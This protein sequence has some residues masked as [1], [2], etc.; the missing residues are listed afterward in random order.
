[1]ADNDNHNPN[2]SDATQALQGFR[3]NEEWDALLAEVNA[4]IESINQIPYPNVS[5]QV[6]ALLQGI[7]AIHREALHRLVRLFKEGVLEQVIT[8]PAICTL[9]ELYDLLPAE[10]AKPN[11]PN[12]PIK[13]IPKTVPDTNRLHERPHWVP[14]LQSIDELKNGE[15]K[16]V[17]LDDKEILLCRNEDKL[18]AIDNV[19]TQDGSSLESAKLKGYTLICPNHAACL[20]DIRQGNR[21]ASADKVTC[22]RVKTDENGRILIGLGIEFQPNG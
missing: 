22:Y 2:P 7:D 10:Q 12:I 5:E 20:Y 19:C 6:F 16:T 18:F 8:D 9:M 11:F 4:Q 13:V 15:V 17:S 21:I 3:S 14:V 1:M